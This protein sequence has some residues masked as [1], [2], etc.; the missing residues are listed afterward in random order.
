[1]NDD[2]NKLLRE[3]YHWNKHIYNKLGGID[4]NAL[5]RKRQ[6][7]EGD[8]QIDSM[9]RY[10][11]VAKNLPGVKELLEKEF[12]MK[13]KK[14]Q[15]SHTILKQ[16][17]PDYFGWRDEED[18]VL[19]ELEK[20]TKIHNQSTFPNKRKRIKESDTEV[21][22]R[23]NVT[24]EEYDTNDGD[25]NEFEFPFKA[26]PTPEDVANIILERKKKDLIAR[27]ALM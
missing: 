19:L 9:Y 13:Q 18:G 15:S 11:G 23:K 24:D 2:I 3:K 12:L 16:L 5:E 1:M 10:F 27:Y 26:P 8:T 6:I 4:Y 22:N 25:D 14:L 17:T 21:G 20:K 7:E